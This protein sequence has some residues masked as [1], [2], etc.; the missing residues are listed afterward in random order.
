MH[1]LLLNQFFHPDSAAT[2]QLLTDLAGDLAARG[3][4]VRV[5]AA[6]STYASAGSSGPVGVEVQ[7]VKT[8]QF[9]NSIPGRLSSYLAYFVGV[10][11]ACLFGPKP[12]CIVTMTTPPGLSLVGALMK[13]L[14]GVPHICWE[15]DMYPD[16][17]VGLG[18]LAAGSPVTRLTSLLF[19]AAVRGADA[20]VVL[21][22]C[23]ENLL[24]RKGVKADRIH[25]V[26][27]WADGTVVVPRPMPPSPL[28]IIYSGNL[29][30]AHDIETVQSVLADS[31]AR[32]VFAGGGPLRPAFEAYCRDANLTKVEFKSYCSLHELGES[33]AQSHIGL[34]TQRPATLGTL[35]PSKTYGIMAAGRPVLFIGPRESTPALLIA[36]HGCGWHVEPGDS[37]GLLALL[38]H[39]AAHP[40]EIAA[41]GAEARRVFLALYDKRVALGHL[42]RIINSVGRASE[43]PLPARAYSQYSD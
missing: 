40:D 42:N 17:A 39:L 2:S 10:L 14:R 13:R 9:S 16:V 41:A 29:G 32:W 33:L 26:E 19:G 4:R 34:V 28:S 6:T 11:S 43:G 20:A 24:R 38:E 30:R 3:H 35:V 37:K 15:M 23:M 25:V 36:R 5:V 22:P 12:D 21:G 31:S 1:I 8:P 7:R 27:N 18:V